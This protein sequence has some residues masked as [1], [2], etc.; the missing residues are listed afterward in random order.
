MTKMEIVTVGGCELVTGAFVRALACP[1][2]T[3]SV[4]ELRIG[5]DLWIVKNIG[6]GH[7]EAGTTREV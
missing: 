1:V 6:A 5:S 2:V 4:K 7:T 3:K